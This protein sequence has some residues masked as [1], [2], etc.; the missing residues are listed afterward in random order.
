M[1]QGGGYKQKVQRAQRR[2]KIIMLLRENPGYTH[3]DLADK[4]SCNRGTISSDLK[5]IDAELTI[6]NREDFDAEL[7]IQN[8]ED[9]MLHRDRILRELQSNKDECMRRLNACSNPAQGSRWMEEWSKLTEK[10]IR[11]LGVNM[12]ERLHIT[13]EE[14]ASK[15]DQDKAVDAVIGF[16][17]EDVIDVEAEEIVPQITHIKKDNDGSSDT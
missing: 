4:L 17:D 9:F 13:N 5:A 2:K 12:P 6:Q 14:I 7:T 10:E 8:R 16:L 11:M 1:L 3:Q 15:E